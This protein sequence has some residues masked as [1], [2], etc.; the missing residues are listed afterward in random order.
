M[1]GTVRRSPK[2][3]ALEAARFVWA[4]FLC[5]ACGIM[6]ISR[7]LKPQPHP[8]PPASFGWALVAVA[9]VDI[10]F[11]GLL[12]RN[13][14]ARSQQQAMQGD[15]TAAQASWSVAQ[16][17]GMAAAESIVLFGFVLSVLHTRPS[18]L[19]VAFYAVGLLL[20]VSYLPQRPD[21]G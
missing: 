4:A 6:A 16:L 1:T 2:P 11:F 17:L 8:A 7:I 12:R 18:W 21:N 15:S 13:I 3:L 19:H 10:V 14:L 5:S 9:A 20:L